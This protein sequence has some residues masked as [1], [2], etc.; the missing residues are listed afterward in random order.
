[1]ATRGIF[2]IYEGKSPVAQAEQT[3]G[4]SYESAMALV[5]EKMLGTGYKLYVDNF[6]T[7]PSL[8]RDL[9]QKGIWACGTIRSNR[10]GFPQATDNRLPRNAPRGSIRW[11]RNDKL[12]FVEWKDTREVLMCSSFHSANG[13]RTVQMRTRSGEWTALTVPIP[14]AVADYK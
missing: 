5:D 1:M 6:Y 9:L 8:F 2:F 4:L 3:K 7:S 14:A 12:L 13:A 10:V 11:I